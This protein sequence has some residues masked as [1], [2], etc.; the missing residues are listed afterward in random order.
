MGGDVNV[1]V[2]DTNAWI[3]WL[4]DPSKL[5]RKARN[6]IKKAT[7]NDDATISVISLWEVAVKVQIGK[8]YLPMD[9]DLWWARA[10]GYPGISLEVLIPQDALSS[11]RLPGV[12]HRDPADRFIVA[13]ARR[14]GCPLVTADRKIID[15]PHVE[16]IW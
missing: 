8:L 9:I 12:F 16:T 5:T 7:D 6:A 15:Y 14:H 2:L 10:K 4:H 13:V 11:T 3:W 1:I